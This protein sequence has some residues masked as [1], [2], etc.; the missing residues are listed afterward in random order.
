MGRAGAALDYPHSQL[1]HT[2]G[3]NGRDK[4]FTIRRCLFMSE[5]DVNT[6]TAG[7]HDGAR[8][9]EQAS[10]TDR[11]SRPT[12]PE[13]SYY[14]SGEGSIAPSLPGGGGEAT[15]A[16]SET[17]PPVPGF[18]ISHV[19]DFEIEARGNREAAAARLSSEHGI[20]LAT[21]LG[22]LAAFGEDEVRVRQ[23]IHRSPQRHTNQ[24]QRD[25]CFIILSWLS[26]CA[27]N[28]ARCL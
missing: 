5:K 12:S 9:M 17:A 6:S 20:P 3:V 14:T 13:V 15:G 10:A 8:D 27:R 25:L 4:C 18:P 2:P 26:T 1:N 21:A 11:G 23:W 19:L 24:V 22:A 16:E 28:I 7:I